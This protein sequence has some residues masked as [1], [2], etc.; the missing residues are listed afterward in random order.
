MEMEKAKRIQRYYDYCRLAIIVII[1][2]L[3]AYITL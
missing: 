2:G 3:L 1:V